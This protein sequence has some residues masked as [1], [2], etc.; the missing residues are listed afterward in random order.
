MRP[1]S[2][3]ATLHRIALPLRSTCGSPVGSG[4]DRLGGAS[5]TEGVVEL[6]VGRSWLSAT[7]PVRANGHQRLAVLINDIPCA[8][9]LLLGLTLQLAWLPVALVAVE[10]VPVIGD[11]LLMPEANAVAMPSNSRQS[12][13]ERSASWTLTARSSPQATSSEPQAT[14]ESRCDRGPAACPVS[15]RRRPRARAAFGVGLPEDARW[16]ASTPGR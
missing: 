11:H 3:Q 14:G 2:Q 12:R 13:L 15:R 1:H 4:D 7:G 5:V 10:R 9:A 8:V 6:A 16:L